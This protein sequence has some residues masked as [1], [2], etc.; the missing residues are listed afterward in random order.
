MKQI[1]NISIKWKDNSFFLSF[2]KSGFQI[3]GETN[4]FFSVEGI[5]SKM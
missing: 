3:Y 4:N 1:T 2:S 5:L